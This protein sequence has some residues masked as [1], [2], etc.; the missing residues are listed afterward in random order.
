MFEKS[1]QDKKKNHLKI[2]RILKKKGRKI[3]EQIRIKMN[4]YLLNKK[5]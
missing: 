1:C 2:A 3:C 4:Q 5:P